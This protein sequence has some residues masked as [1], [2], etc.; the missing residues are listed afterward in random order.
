MKKVFVVF[1]CIGA[2]VLVGCGGKETPE[3]FGKKYVEKKFANLNCDL[4][5]LKYTVTE[6]GK[7]AAKVVI[8][9]KINYK[10]EIKLVKKDG[11]WVVG[12]KESKKAAP[13]KTADVKKETKAETHAPAKTELKDTHAKE[14]EKTEPAHH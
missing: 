8:E 2:L 12:V 5:G 9:G 4:A 6:D 13:E 7:D 14:T 3:T 10:E 1:C 11:E